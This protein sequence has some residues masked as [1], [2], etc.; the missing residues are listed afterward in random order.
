MASARPP[1]RRELSELPL[2]FI[3]VARGSDLD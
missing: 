3:A 1:A 2:T